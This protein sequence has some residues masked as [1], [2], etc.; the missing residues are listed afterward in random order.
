MARAWN[1]AIAEAAPA[2]SPVHHAR[3]KH[4]REASS[5]LH[6]F[7]HR[8]G[9]V[10]WMPAD[11]PSAPAVGT[12]PAVRL[13]AHH[14]II[15]DH[16]YLSPHLIALGRSTNAR[17]KADRNARGGR[18]DGGR[19]CRDRAAER[20]R[21]P[22][23]R[24]DRQ[25]LAR[26]QPQQQAPDPEP[27]QVRELPEECHPRDRTRRVLRPVGRGRDVQA[28]QQRH[29][30]GRG[31]GP[32]QLHDRASPVRR[33]AEGQRAHQR[34][35]RHADLRQRRVRRH[36]PDDQVLLAKRRDPARWGQGPGHQHL[37]QV[38][39]HQRHPRRHG[40]QV[41]HLHQRSS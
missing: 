10:S 8:L 13:L 15:G 23:P 7:V 38:G 36:N 33:R 2:T 20:G 17:N 9:R 12:L 4:G 11:P 3:A 1:R 18:V 34:R 22:D 16:L 21:G 41:L 35:V 27:G 24:P 25:R 26:A 14:K 40:Q 29:E 28:L 30:P 32:G 37:R 39:A 5:S 31:P 6:R 19:R